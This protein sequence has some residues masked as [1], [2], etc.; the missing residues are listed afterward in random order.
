MAEPPRLVITPDGPYA[1]TSADMVTVLFARSR[2][3]YSTGRL[4]PGAPADAVLLCRCGRSGSLP[5]CDETCERSGF[6]ADPAG[7]GPDTSREAG[8]QPRLA[9]VEN[10]PIMVAGMDVVHEDGSVT[11]LTDHEA[12]LCR[13]GASNDKPWCDFSHRVV[14]Y[15]SQKR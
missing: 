10:G 8:V 15:C 2:S 13:C 4:T 1:V 7:R 9:F 6:Q 3:D 14:R 11:S 5:N 12:P